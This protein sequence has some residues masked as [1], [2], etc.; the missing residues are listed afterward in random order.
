[1]FSPWGVFWCYQSIVYSFNEIRMHTGD[2]E[3]RVLHGASW[4]SEFA[5]SGRAGFWRR[6]VRTGR[7]AWE[8][9][10]PRPG[11][12]LDPVRDAFSVLRLG[13]VRAPLPSLVARWL[14]R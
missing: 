6:F 7:G 12:R 10:R 9:Y 5:A 3:D 8:R 4:Y 13:A 2:P 1:M 14:P 11:S